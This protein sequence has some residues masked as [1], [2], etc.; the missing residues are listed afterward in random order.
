MVVFGLRAKALVVGE[1]VR[2]CCRSTLFSDSKLKTFSW[3]LI[4]RKEKS[5]V[6]L[7]ILGKEWALSAISDTN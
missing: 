6:S 7:L 2:V 4:Y 1:M 3:N 5:F